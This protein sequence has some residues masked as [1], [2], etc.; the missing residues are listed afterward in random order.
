MKITNIGLKC[1]S[2]STTYLPIHQSTR[3]VTVFFSHQTLCND[4]VKYTFIR[5]SRY[6]VRNNNYIHREP[7]R[8][9]SRRRNGPGATGTPSHLK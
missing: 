5:Q 8:R 9:R 2:F 1:L 6:R 3:I 4:L 7:H